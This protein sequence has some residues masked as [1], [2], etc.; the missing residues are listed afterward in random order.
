M[1]FTAN[2][3]GGKYESRQLNCGDSSMGLPKS[4]NYSDRTIVRDLPISSNHSE[5]NAHISL[6][7]PYLVV[8]F[9][10]RIK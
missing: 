6:M 4:T 10:R 3:T 7:Q 9:W 5:I 8:F 1:S 2:S